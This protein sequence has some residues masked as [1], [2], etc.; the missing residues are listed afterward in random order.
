MAPLVNIEA[1]VIN[2]AVKALDKHDD[3]LGFDLRTR[4]VFRV[5][6]V[7]E[8]LGEVATAMIGVSGQNPRKGAIHTATDVHLEL[9]DVIVTCL[10]ALASMRGD[11]GSLLQR[12]IPMTTARMRHDARGARG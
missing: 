10:V 12:Q 5:L 2:G 1:S 8:E 11:W 7:A 6:K 3:E 9:C 4:L